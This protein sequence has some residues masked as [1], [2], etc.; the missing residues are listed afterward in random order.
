MPAFGFFPR[1][2]HHARFFASVADALKDQHE[3]DS[4]FIREMGEVSNQRVFEFD[5]EIENQWHSFDISYEALQALKNAF[6]EFNFMRAIYSERE[7]NFFPSY[8]GVRPVSCEHQLKYLVGCFSVFDQWLSNN[9]IELVVSEMITG[10]ADA[11][12]KAVAEKRGIKYLSVRQSKVEPGLVVCDKFFDEPIGM[13][14]IYLEHLEHGIPEPVKSRAA[15]HISNLREKINRPAYMEVT[16]KPL[17]LLTK[18]KLCLLVERIFNDRIPSNSISARRYPLLQPI[19]WALFKKF[20]VWRTYLAKK[21]LFASDVLEDERFFIFPLHYEPEASTAVRAFYFSDQLALIRLI[22]KVLPLGVKL[23]V[24]EHAGNQGY[25]KPEFYRELS[26]MHNVIMLPPHF[27][28]FSLLRRCNG[29]IT[30]TGRMGWEAIVNQKPVICLGQTFWSLLE[31]VHRV[32]SWQELSSAIEQS[33]GAVPDKNYHCEKSILAF[34]AAYISCTYPGS[35]V[36]NT[37]QLGMPANI[38]AFVE[39]L[40]DLRGSSEEKIGIDEM[41]AA[42]RGN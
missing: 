5:R 19:G 25:R 23:V 8:F 1:N 12:F 11:V 27:D 14:Q 26:Y 41:P 29:V 15:E 34:A 33:C 30:L 22:A 40:V 28:V 42:S 7:F 2:P 9:S 10:L 6:P 31:S 39:M 17:K 20:N 13:L 16:S 38:N 24:K 21:K 3:I 35:F 18:K 37:E 32:E 4:L 36:L